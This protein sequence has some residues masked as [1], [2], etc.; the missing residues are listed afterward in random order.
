MY[1]NA[2]LA[3]TVAGILAVLLVLVII[4]NFREGTAAG[5]VSAI[6]TE[7]QKDCTAADAASRMHC[8]QTLSDLAR[9]LSQFS[10]V[11]TGTTTRP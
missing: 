4:L 8:S 11:L 6:R 1:R 3:W 5:G 10:N 9:T 7:L 2:P